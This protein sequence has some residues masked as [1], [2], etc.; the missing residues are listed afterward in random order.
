MTPLGNGMPPPPHPGRH[1][2]RAIPEAARRESPWS[3]QLLSTSGHAGINTCMQVWSRSAGPSHHPQLAVHIRAACYITSP[4]NCCTLTSV[5]VLV[6][7]KFAGQAEHFITQAGRTHRQNTRHC[8]PEGS[9]LGSFELLCPVDTNP[10]LPLLAICWKVSCN[11]RLF[12]T[13]KGRNR[14][15][16]NNLHNLTDIAMFAG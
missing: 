9:T 14:Q 7:G 15:K 4:S 11:L 13:S 5:C 12:S 2:G 1:V 6:A 3:P 8:R 16:T 10:L